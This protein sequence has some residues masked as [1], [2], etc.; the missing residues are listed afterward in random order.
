MGVMAGF[1]G[2]VTRTGVRKD[3]LTQRHAARELEKASW[4]GPG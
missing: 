3:D 4:L 2:S 1:Q